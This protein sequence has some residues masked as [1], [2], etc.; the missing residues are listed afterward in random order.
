MPIRLDFG[1]DVGFVL[2]VLR[3]YYRRCWWFWVD[4]NGKSGVE[5][6]VD[7]VFSGI[8]NRWRHCRLV[9]L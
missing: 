3:F 8:K 6:S 7:M 9:A 4:W 1:S 5:E 2:E